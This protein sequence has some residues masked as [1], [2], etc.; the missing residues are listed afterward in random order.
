MRNKIF[1]ALF[2]AITAAILCGCGKNEVP[3]EST[4]VQ[5]AP[6]I[7]TQAKTT[8][9]TTK[10]APTTEAETSDVSQAE[11]ETNAQAQ[12]QEETTAETEAQSSQSAMTREE[13]ISWVLSDTGAKEYAEY[14][15]DKDGNSELIV[16]IGEGYAEQHCEVYTIDE[17]GS[18]LA[19]SFASANTTLYSADDGLTLFYAHMGGYTYTTARLV[20][21]ALILTDEGGGR[22]EGDY[23][24]V[25]GEI[26]AFTS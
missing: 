5:T 18:S 10:A 4:T 24:S 23:P 12:T 16:N 21:G 13:V 20:D 17:N 26:I 19:G 2:A 11:A 14:D 25:D 7:T 3:A 1:A 9:A 22:T 6:Q 15:I 8:A